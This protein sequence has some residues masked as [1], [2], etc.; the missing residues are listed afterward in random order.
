MEDI[1]KFSIVLR[2]NGEWNSTETDFEKQNYLEIVKDVMDFFD[3]II[4]LSV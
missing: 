1:K 3:I 4:T 2:R